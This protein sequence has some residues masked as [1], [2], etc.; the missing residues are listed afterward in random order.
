MRPS[1]AADIYSLHSDPRMYTYIDRQVDRSL[2]DSK[3][4]VKRIMQGQ[5]SGKFLYWM[6]HRPPSKDAIGTLCLFNFAL[7]GKHAEIG[8]EL[9]PSHW[10][11]GIMKQ[12]V[13]LL[14]DFAFDELGVGQLQAV[15]H[16]ENA[17]SCRLMESNGFKWEDD[18]PSRRADFPAQRVYRLRR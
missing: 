9:L 10:G 8:Y 4:F 14:I 2:N 6:L 15:V 12:C 5:A 17:A 16:P 3:D 13:P 1:D 11:S 18:L 7:D